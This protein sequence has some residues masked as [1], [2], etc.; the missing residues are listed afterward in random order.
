MVILLQ[1]WKFIRTTTSI[2]INTVNKMSDNRIVEE[3]TK[4]K[5]GLAELRNE[6][7][8]RIGVKIE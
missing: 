6:W 5:G 1:E 3:V 7:D 4:A 8:E 2:K